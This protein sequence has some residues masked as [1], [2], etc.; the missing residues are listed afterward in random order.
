MRPYY[1]F[2]SASEC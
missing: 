2:A 1:F